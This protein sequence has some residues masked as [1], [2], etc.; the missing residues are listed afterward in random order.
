MILGTIWLIFGSVIGAMIHTEHSRI[1][2][3]ER[4][5]LAAQV[6]VVEQ[7]LAQQLIAANHILGSLRKDLP[8]LQ[9]QQINNSSMVTRRLRVMSEAMP[10]VRTLLVFDA[11]GTII[12][13][14]R[15]ELVGQ[16]FKER[17]YFKTARQSNDPGA[18]YVSPPFKTVLG[19]FA[20]NLVRVLSDEHGRFAGIVS[21]TLDPGYFN[22]LLDSVRYAPDMQTFLMHGDGKVFLSMPEEYLF[23]NELDS[24]YS[25]V[26]AETQKVAISTGVHKD[27]GEQF[28]V[29]RQTIKPDSIAMDKALGVIIERDLPSVFADWKQSAYQL[30][31]LFGALILFSSLGLIYYQRR[32]RAFALLAAQFEAERQRTE[33][34]VRQMAFHD[35]LTHLPNRR[36]LHD[37]LGHA[38][39]ASKRHGCYGAL[40]FMDLDN[41]KPLNDTQGHEVGDLLLIEV[42]NRLTRCVREVDT[43]ARFGGDEFV[44]MLKELQAE[45][46]ESSELAESIANKIRLALAEPY[47]LTI[48]HH[49]DKE[50]VVKHHCTASIGVALFIHHEGSQDDIMKRADT[51]MYQAKEAGRNVVMVAQGTEQPFAAPATSASSFLKLV[52]HPNY[53]C[54]NTLINHQHRALF[55]DANKLL[56]AILFEKPEKDIAGLLDELIRD[57]VQHFKDEEVIFKATGFPGAEEH[58]AIHRRLID[59]MLIQRGHFNAGTLQTG[60]LF[61]YLAHDVIAK[62]MLGDDRAFFPYLNSR[63]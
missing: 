10:G 48:K 61:Q 12:Y 42:A 36:L 60:D 27:T 54:A 51:A 52:W 23:E 15:E 26:S 34:A 7:N 1:D 14:T 22:T 25:Q 37:R 18:L 58:A 45:R 39:A 17:A 28:M 56:S 2:T 40:M 21:L 5:R 41:F 19:V 11:E 53:K 20:I 44:V 62:H 59:D 16:N 33:E 63:H 46:A 43:V 3:T 4:S 8:I 38:M 6:K 31:V 30:A 35:P 55:S 29:A 50:T 57:V 32:Q 13:A 49:G 47:L 9:K 24:R